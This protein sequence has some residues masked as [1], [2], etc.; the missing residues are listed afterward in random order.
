MKCDNLCADYC[1]VCLDRT[2]ISKNLVNDILADCYEKDD[3]FAYELCVDKSCQRCQL[4]T[5]NT[6]CSYYYYILL[7]TRIMFEGEL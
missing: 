5:P 7:A 2:C 3:S 4:F 6:N 1:C